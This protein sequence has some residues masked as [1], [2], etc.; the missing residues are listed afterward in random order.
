MEGEGPQQENRLLQGGAL[1]WQQIRALLP[2]LPQ[3]QLPAG[4]VQLQGKILKGERDAAETLL[5]EA[6]ELAPALHH[7]YLPLFEGVN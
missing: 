1:E 3:L 5:K 7:E 4:T 2:R 6:N